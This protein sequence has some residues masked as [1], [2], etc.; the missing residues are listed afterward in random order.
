MHSGPGTVRVA[1]VDSDSGFV[2]V[3]AKRLGEAGA[4]ARVFGGP[5]PSD[6]L[7]AM[8]ARAIVLDAGLLGQRTFP[9]L[10]RLANEFPTL[11]TVVTA[12]T[13]TLVQ[14]VRALRSGADHWVSKPCHPL[15]V[16]AC[17]EAALRR[18]DP[19]RGIELV[20]VRAG[21]LV[22]RPDRF[23]AYAG[24]RSAQLTRKEFEL[25]RVLANATAR[26]VAREEIYA[27]VWGWTLPRGDRSV[28]VLVRKV[29]SKLRR[30]LPSWEFIHT[31][32][33]VGYRFE[34]QQP[35]PAPQTPSPSG[36]EGP[37]KADVPAVVEVAR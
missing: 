24:D 31:H 10:E 16:V 9:Q 20:P 32:F 34:P 11:A 29:R 30:I 5:P 36:V 22:I 19:L 28:D 21:E 15:E 2:R 4:Q 37:K 8:R 17:I 6:E 33:G 25:L 13:S 14:R 3:L 1:V 26:V 12:Q 18:G 27:A 23:Q 7:R 35:G